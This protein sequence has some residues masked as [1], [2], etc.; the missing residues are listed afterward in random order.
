MGMLIRRH[1]KGVDAARQVEPT[2]DDPTLPTP[3]IVV[4]TG[5]PVPPSGE[6][7]VPTGEVPSGPVDPPQ[8]E[9]AVAEGTPGG[10]E[11]TTDHV[12]TFDGQTTSEVQGEVPGTSAES[13]DVPSAPTRNASKAAWLEY[14][15][16]PDTD[17][18]SRDELAE[19]VLGPKQ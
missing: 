5:V 11:E 8:G 1:R 9:E 2:E 15:G 19:S 4:E 16:L 3:P 13:S 14:L 17:T 18:R 7:T 6:S 10:A 12:G